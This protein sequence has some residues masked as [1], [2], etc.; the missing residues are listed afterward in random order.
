LYSFVLLIYLFVRLFIYLFANFFVFFFLLFV[1][2]SAFTL[3]YHYITSLLVWQFKWEEGREK[4]AHEEDTGVSNRGRVLETIE[5]TRLLLISHMI[6]FLFVSF[7]FFLF[8]R[9]F[10]PLAPRVLS[11]SSGS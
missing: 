5:R 3:S 8:L 4:E 1:F 10:Q 6:C 7:F 9:T 2:S 11:V